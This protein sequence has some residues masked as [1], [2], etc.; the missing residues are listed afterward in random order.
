MKQYI[1]TLILTMT[2][3]SSCA[4]NA[5]QTDREFI[6]LQELGVL[7]L[8]TAQYEEAISTFDKAITLKS[9]NS[10]VLYNKVLAL[11]ANKDFP[12]AQETAKL[13][14]SRFPANLEFLMAKAWA[15]IQLN[16]NNEALATYLGIIAL[17][18]GNAARRAL[19]M[20]FALEKGFVSE[21]KEQA[22]FLLSVHKEEA[23]AFSVLAALEG[24]E[25]WYALAKEFM[26]GVA[27]QSPALQQPQSK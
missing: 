25:S 9:Q 27:A 18:P 19:I 1:L 3:L 17:D 22:L 24:D 26:K 4:T 16:Q 10:E 7:Y 14:F 13:G 2:L 12:K 20:E 15:E 21:A 23:R 6:A 8:D 5:A 11:L